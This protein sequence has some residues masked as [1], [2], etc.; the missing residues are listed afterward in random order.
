MY[1]ALFT[2]AWRH[3]YSETVVLTLVSRMLSLQPLIP[4]CPSGDVSKRTTAVLIGTAL[5][6]CSPLLPLNATF[7]TIQNNE[8]FRNSTRG[9]RP[10]G[11]LG[12]P[13]SLPLPPLSIKPPLASRLPGRRKITALSAKCG[14]CF[15][16]ISWLG[17]YS[18]SPPECKRRTPCCHPG[19][20]ACLLSRVAG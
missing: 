15:S 2:L 6:S 5:S 13:D 20:L 19:C 8:P 11:V 9:S 7:S 10:S 1:W 3:L 16:R 14:R 18:L 12:S 17:E 4:I